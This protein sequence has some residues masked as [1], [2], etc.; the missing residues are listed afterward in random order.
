VVLWDALE[1]DFVDYLFAH[2]VGVPLVYV[3]AH[4][5]DFVLTVADSTDSDGSE[6]LA[7]SG[8]EGLPE[9]RMGR[10]GG[11]SVGESAG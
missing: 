8:A 11:V 4:V 7:E 2:L 9:V 1:D 10:V 3:V 6:A 5:G